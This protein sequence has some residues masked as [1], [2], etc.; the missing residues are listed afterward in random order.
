MSQ[1]RLKTYR[2]RSGKVIEAKPFTSSAEA[3]EAIRDE[4]YKNE[5]AY[6]SAIQQRLMR[7][8]NNED[9][10]ENTDHA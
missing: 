10:R 9:H 5:P 6:R 1:F 4:R 8:H 7:T 3:V 2:L